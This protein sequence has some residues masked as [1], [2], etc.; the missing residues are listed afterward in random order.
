MGAE[1]REHI[2]QINIARH[3]T[4]A[5]GP[6]STSAETRTEAIPQTATTTQQDDDDDEQRL[7]TRGRPRFRSSNFATS[8]YLLLMPPPYSIVPIVLLLPVH[9]G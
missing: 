3:A 6:R 1:S 9:D 4:E 5:D 8:S 2:G 7:E